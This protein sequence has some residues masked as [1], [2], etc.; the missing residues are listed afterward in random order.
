LRRKEGLLPREGL[1]QALQEVSVV[2]LPPSV[3]E[4]MEEEDL[5]TIATLVVAGEA[6]GT[7]LVN[8]YA[9]RVERMLNAYGPTEATVCAS[10]S[11]PLR[12]T[13]RVPIGKPLENS[14]L[15][16]LDGEMGV[17]PV[18]IVG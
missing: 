13:E 11:G 7:A 10:I 8:K 12:A 14:R 3:L 2:T 1:R 18:G 4:V 6:C 17:L 5:A 15:Y 16:V 9:G